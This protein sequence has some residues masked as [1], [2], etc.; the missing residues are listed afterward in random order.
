M[1]AV[2]PRT[3]RPVGD[4]GTANQAIAY[5]LDEHE[6]DPGNQVEFMRAWRE[7]DLADEWPDYYQWLERQE[8]G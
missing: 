4:H 2:D 1:A 8:A 6:A 3:G 7:G 5:M